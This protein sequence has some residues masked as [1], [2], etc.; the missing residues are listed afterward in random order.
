MKTQ[1]MK[2]AVRAAVIWAGLTGWAK[3]ESPWPKDAPATTYT[4][5]VLNEP[6]NKGEPKATVYAIRPGVK[7]GFFDHF[8]LW[9][10]SESA[11]QVA[12]SVVS[13]R[14]GRFRLTVPHGYATWLLVT[15]QDRRLSGNVEQNLKRDVRD[16]TIKL[17]PQMNDIAFSGVV[18][19]FPDDDQKM[20]Q[21]AYYKMMF[22][23]ASTGY[24][25]PLSL[26]AYEQKGIV[27]PDES[28][29]MQKYWRFLSGPKP[30]IT[31][32][33]N[34]FSMRIISVSAPVVFR[35]SERYMDPVPGKPIQQ[36]DLSHLNLNNW[37]SE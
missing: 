23:Y 12:A 36:I 1:F 33:W 32:G 17:D 25:T 31:V 19:D 4:G 18:G 10:T 8:R 5:V 30:A 16:L 24:E 6:L 22:H 13:D 3:S 11:D 2:A 29:M 7:P 37:P 34:C 15:S 28:R 21:S 20:I 35:P 14:S 27:S 26:A 9:Q